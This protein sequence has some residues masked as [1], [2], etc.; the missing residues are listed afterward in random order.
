MYMFET[1]KSIIYMLC[2]ETKSSRVRVTYL[3]SGWNVC[4]AL[5]GGLDRFWIRR[6]GPEVRLLILDSKEENKREVLLARFEGEQGT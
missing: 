2:H 5:S 6:E 3:A 1:N 4:W